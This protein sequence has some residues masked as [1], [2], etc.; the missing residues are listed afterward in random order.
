MSMLALS[1][2]LGYDSI[3]PQALTCTVIENGVHTVCS[4]FHTSTLCVTLMN[5][6][7]GVGVTFG[8]VTSSHD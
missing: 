3:D 5:C 1:L 4:D 8:S 2:W 7:V 6:P